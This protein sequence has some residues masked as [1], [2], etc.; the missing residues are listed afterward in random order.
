LLSAQHGLPD[1]VADY[2]VNGSIVFE[3]HFMF[4]RV[5]VDINAFR[6]QIDFDDAGRIA[7]L[8]HE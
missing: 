8:E 7:A 4:G 2:L 3:A 6:W 1:R 5:D